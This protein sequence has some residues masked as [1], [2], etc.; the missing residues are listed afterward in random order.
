MPQS[1]RGFRTIWQG[2]R[3]GRNGERHELARPQ[4]SVVI[5]LKAL[6][7]AEDTPDAMHYHGFAREAEIEY[8]ASLVMGMGAFQVGGFSRAE[9]P[10]AVPRFYKFLRL[11]L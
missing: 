5:A 7:F 3:T 9:C 2:Q 1:S 10:A 11:R 6:P 8:A 4:T